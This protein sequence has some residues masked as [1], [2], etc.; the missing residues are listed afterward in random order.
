MGRKKKLTRGK[1]VPTNMGRITR[2]RF[3]RLSQ[4][5]KFRVFGVV[6]RLL[7]MGPLL[8]ERSFQTRWALF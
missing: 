4:G 6:L 2:V 7:R 5:M 8:R 1:P 3:P